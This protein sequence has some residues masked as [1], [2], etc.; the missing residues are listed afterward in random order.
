MKQRQPKGIPK[1]TN[2]KPAMSFPFV[3]PIKEDLVG[4][5]VLDWFITSNK[6]SV[7]TDAAFERDYCTMRATIDPMLDQNDSG[8]LTSDT[9][10]KKD[11]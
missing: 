6:S 1:K 9:V 11:T 3:A 5:F 7:K 8:W 4:L 10:K 2:N